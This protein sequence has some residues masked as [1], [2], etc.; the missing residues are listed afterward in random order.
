MKKDNYKI[1]ILVI[2]IIIAISVD[3]LLLLYW[4]PYKTDN[5]K[6]NY[7]LCS[8]EEDIGTT[9]EEVNIDGKVLKNV[10]VFEYHINSKIEINYDE[11]NDTYNIIENEIE[12]FKNRSYY[13]ANK[14]FY[15]SN[16]TKYTILDDENMVLLFSTQYGKKSN[17]I[18]DFINVLQEDEWICQ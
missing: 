2:L 8:K 14:K 5:K 18:S 16:E 3:I 1:I 15:D 11:E 17:E 12:T 4:K 10:P 6:I 7:K 9:K 13:E